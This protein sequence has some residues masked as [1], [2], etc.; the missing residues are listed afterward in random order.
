ME[1]L[2]KN[3]FESVMNTITEA[4]YNNENYKYIYN[5]FIY[6]LLYIDLILPILF[7]LT[8]GGKN[9]INNREIS[10]EQ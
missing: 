5:I 6:V 9:K 7:F 3:P 8:D 4:L 1:N 10:S 2:Y